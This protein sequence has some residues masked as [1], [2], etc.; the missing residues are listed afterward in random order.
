MLF[1]ELA[2]RQ[3]WAN[4][5]ATMFDLSNLTKEIR[6]KVMRTLFANNFLLETLL[7]SLMYVDR[8]VVN[9]SNLRQ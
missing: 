9:Q 2:S 6:T 3:K 7:Y 4:E 5:Q 8:V 1:D